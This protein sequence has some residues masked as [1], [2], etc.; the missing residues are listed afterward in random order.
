L[1]SDM[2]RACESFDGCGTFS[3]PNPTFGGARSRTDALDGVR[4]NLAAMGRWSDDTDWPFRSGSRAGPSPSLGSGEW[5][6][7][8]KWWFEETEGELEA[9]V[10][11][12]RSGW[13]SGST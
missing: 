7:W 2:S 13:S 9:E 5:W 12:E 4:E 3:I 10:E 8:P 1:P 6:K 11:G